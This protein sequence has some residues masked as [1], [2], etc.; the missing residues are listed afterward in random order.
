M[1]VTS[2]IKSPLPPI[3]YQACKQW[4]QYGDV[5]TIAREK[6]ISLSLAYK[7]LN[8]KRKHF[9]F[10]AAVFQKAIDN[11]DRMKKLQEILNQTNK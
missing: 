10:I 5:A 1:N 9:E 11:R 3:D 8:G 2:A 7:I 6:N 4:L